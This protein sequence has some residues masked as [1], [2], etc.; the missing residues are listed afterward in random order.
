MANQAVGPEVLVGQTL[1]HYRILDRIGAGGMGEV[2]RARDEHLDR[3]V[4][5]KVLPPRSFA[6]E[7]ARKRFRKEALTLSKLN[8]PNIAT[9]HDFD[10]QQ[11]VDF[12]VMEYIPGITLSEKLAARPLPEKE[13]ITLGAQL[14]DGLSAAHE[15]G[16]VHRDLKP[17]NLRLT[18]DGR[19][20]I[21]D[22]GLARLRLP[23]TATAATESLTE[24]ESMGGTL[25][26]MAPEQLLGQETDART[27]IYATGAAIYEM[28][29]GSKPFVE[30]E[31]SQLIAAI[32]HRVP[33]SA[34][35]L[36]A[37]LSPDLD[38]ILRKCLDKKPENRYQSA[39]ELAVDLR[40][41]A[42]GST[43]AYPDVEPPPVSYLVKVGRHKAKL[44]IG[45]TLAILLALAGVFLRMRSKPASGIAPVLP[46]VAVLPFAD[47]SP[48]KNQEYF[49][50]GL[51]EELMNSLAQIPGLKVTGR[52]SS[53][54]FRGKNEDLS[55]IA[56]KLHVATIL[57]GSVRKQGNRIRITAQLVKAADGFH[58]W[59]QTYDRDLT[60]VFAVQEEIASSVAGSLQVALLGQR[61]SSARATNPDAYAAYLEGRYFAR[62]SNRESW[63]QAVHY[64]RRAIEL[65]PSYAPAWAALASARAL[66]AG[67]EYIPPREGYE[68]AR[69]EVE[70]ALSLDPDLARGYTVRGL[71]K[72]FWDWDWSG[73]DADYQR[74]LALEPG[75][76][77]VVSAA[78]A[79]AARMGRWDQA[80]RLARKA[81]EL[82]PFWAGV[83][84]NLGVVGWRAG[85]FN[86]AEAALLKAVELRPQ[87]QYQHTSLSRVYLA[88]GRPREALTQAEQ[89]R[90]PVFRLQCLSLAYHVLG[91]KRES[92][93]A[94][95][96]LIAK[97]KTNA[98]FQIA[99]IYAFRGEP[100]R[101]F[102]WLDRAYVQHDAGLPDQLVGDPLL[103]S[104]EH[105]LRYA[106][107]FK[108]MRLP[109]IESNPS[110]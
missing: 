21:L 33:R 29:T 47:M 81:V 60:D 53:F 90:Q 19:L 72:M 20:K 22:F 108:K 86:E 2:Y 8:H 73:A 24:P 83:Y 75:N 45:A 11:G 55:A 67:G 66:Q 34:S 13:V 38:P 93:Q 30:L 87:A 7:Q 46:S 92:D 49:S 102:E 14:A 10:S 41:L 95:A 27:D 32:L 6:D 31:H 40:R 35:S 18:E 85:H 107:F 52:T 16:V 105:D 79:H 98:A 15:H 88:K 61:K 71:I 23:V 103:S 26:Y 70:R 43:A 44:A 4:A 12:L 99:E 69:A 28:A 36:N 106:V 109:V 65:D 62:L 59:S 74:A 63:E 39:K 76:Y 57:E 5:I 48:E 84:S 80:V 97:N 100:D 94:L 50:D 56:E 64:Y 101:A 37:R 82:D 68:E 96:E 104:L 58:L 25:P 78:S 9:I 91:Q 3:E 89:E 110:S 17:G 1:G 54:Q 42:G 51:S 77:A